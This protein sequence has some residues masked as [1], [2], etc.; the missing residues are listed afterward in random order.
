LTFLNSIR[1]SS[2]QKKLEPEFGKPYFSELAQFLAIEKQKGAV[3]YPPEAMIFNAFEKTPFKDVKVVVLGQDPYHGFGQAHGLCFS[4]P[5]G[6]KPPP[7]LANIF[8]ELKADVVFQ[9]PDHGNLEAWATQGVLLLNAGLTVGDGQPGSHQGKGWEFFTSAVIKL[10]NDEKQGLI[11]LLWGKPAQLKG[12]IIDPK[13]HHILQAPHPSPFSA[14]KGFFGC[15]H[16][17]KT[18]EILVKGGQKPIAWQI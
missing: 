11:F 18:N 13:R 2:W 7:S 8:K 17:S 9:I 10:L 16:F 14:Y 3:S 5:V 15:G 1:E 6:V 4:V 12:S